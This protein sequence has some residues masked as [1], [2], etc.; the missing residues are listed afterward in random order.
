MLA[1]TLE[2]EVMSA[3]EEAQAY[4]EMDHSQ[5]NQKFVEDLLAS[6]EIQPETKIID[7]GT[8][9]GL[10]PLEFARQTA[11]GNIIG[12]DLSEEMLLKAREHAR[13]ENLDNRIHFQ[14]ADATATS[15]SATS[16]D[17]VMSNSI[18]HHIPEPQRL[19]VE[20]TRLLR[21]G[22]Q[23]F[24]RDLLRP[25][26]A[27]EVENLVQFHAANNTEF[28]QQLLRQSLHAALTI[29]EVEAILKQIPDLQATVTQTS[30]R[31]WTVIGVKL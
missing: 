30:D 26:T 22:G 24:V 20:A 27:P 17:I 25:E 1:R 14:L 21:H 15:V 11:H 5:V 13:K 18:V 19:F 16:Y 23:L 3:P 4:D 9:T 31:H 28:Q 6:I 2:P 7:L 8:G 12:I 10:I 29:S